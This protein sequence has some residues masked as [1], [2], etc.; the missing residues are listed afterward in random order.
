V[1]RYR[2]AAVSWAV[3]VRFGTG[4]TGVICVVFLRVGQLP[5]LGVRVDTRREEKL[6][7]AVS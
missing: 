1:F 5:D 2:L 6:M 4:R 3:R 7:Q